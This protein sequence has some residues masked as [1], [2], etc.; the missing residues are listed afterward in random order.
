MAKRSACCVIN[1][2][3]SKLRVFGGTPDVRLYGV[4]AMPVDNGQKG[5]I[6]KAKEDVGKCR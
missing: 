3:S 5:A 1:A 2:I 4:G 6:A